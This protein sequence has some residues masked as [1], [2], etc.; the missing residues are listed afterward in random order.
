MLASCAALV[1]AILLTAAAPADASKPRVK[2]IFQKAKV[3]ADGVLTPGQ[4]ETFSVTRLAPQAPVRVFIEPPPVTL[5]C[6]EFFFCDPAPAGPTAGSP[7]FRSDKKGRA[8]LTFVT[9]DTYYLETDPFNP[10][11]RQPCKFMNQQ[12]VHIDVDAASRTK[13]A[14]VESFGFARAT[15]VLAS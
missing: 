7:P 11:I 2:F 6:G 4:V 10:M 8:T 12:R 1:L 13:R 14:K 3:V 15:V 5:Q 9:P